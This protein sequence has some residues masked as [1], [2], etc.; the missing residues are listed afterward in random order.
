MAYLFFQYSIMH[1]IGSVI[2]FEMLAIVTCLETR[3]SVN[4]TVDQTCCPITH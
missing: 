1:T 3:K 4:T 2:H